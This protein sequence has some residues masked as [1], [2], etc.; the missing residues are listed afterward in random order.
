ML[1]KNREKG[2]VYVTQLDKLAFQFGISLTSRWDRYFYCL[3]FEAF[4]VTCPVQRDLWN[5]IIMTLQINFQERS[6]ISRD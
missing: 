4:M 5:W 1:H 2:S 3:H 6:S